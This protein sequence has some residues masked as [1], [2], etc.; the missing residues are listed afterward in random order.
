MVPLYYM[1][2]LSN[3]RI[4]K[5][6]LVPIGAVIA[7]QAQADALP[8]KTE[9]NAKFQNEVLEVNEEFAEN[10]SKLYEE[11]DLMR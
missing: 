3:V 5:N 8:L 2:L 9:A 11:G 6:R 1:V 4:G 7:T 10:Y